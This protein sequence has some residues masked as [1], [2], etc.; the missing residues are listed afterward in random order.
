MHRKGTEGTEERVG[1]A[2]PQ[3]RVS[4]FQL[5]PGHAVDG[6]SPDN[7][8][9]AVELVPLGPVLDRPGKAYVSIGGH[10]LRKHELVQHIVDCKT[11][12]GS[13]HDASPSPSALLGSQCGDHTAPSTKLRQAQRGQPV[14]PA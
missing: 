5:Q 7:A 9:L 1:R 2:L 4:A 3:T 14:L 8:C 12:A 6:R 13:P 11:K 10:V